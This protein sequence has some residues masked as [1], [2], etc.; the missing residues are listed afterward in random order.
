MAAWTQRTFAAF[1]CS[2]VIGTTNNPP[3]GYVSR[4]FGGMWLTI[5]SV[6]GSQLPDKT[7]RLGEAA[8]S[9]SDDGNFYACV[10]G[11]SDDLDSEGLLYC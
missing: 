5:T 7:I 2:V 3:E 9:G 1:R 10:R 4:S 8:L 6:Q 11:R